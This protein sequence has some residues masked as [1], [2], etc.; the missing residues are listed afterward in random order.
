MGKSVRAAAG[1]GRKRRGVGLLTCGLGV[2]HCHVRSRTVELE[3]CIGLVACI[4][5]GMY[6]SDIT[7]ADITVGVLRSHLTYI[8][9]TFV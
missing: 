9:R 2:G 5:V 8:C 1:F 3:P 7:R 4:C 6:D